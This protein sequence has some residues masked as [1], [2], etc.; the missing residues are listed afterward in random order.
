M[1]NAALKKTINR[2]FAALLMLTL[3]LPSLCLPSLALDDPTTPYTE[4]AIVYNVDF[5][6]VMYEENA[7]APVYPAGTVKIMTALLAFER[8]SDLSEQ[9]TVTEEMIKGITGNTAGFK[10]G[11]E[12]AVRDLLAALIVSNSNDAACIL[13]FAVAGDILSFVDLMN[14]RAAELGMENTVYTNPTGIHHDQMKT[15]ARDVMKV[16]AAALKYQFYGEF[17]ASATYTVPATNLAESRLLRNRNYFVSTFYNL[18]YYRESIGG[19]SCSYTGQAGTCLALV[20]ANSEGHRFITVIMGAE[21]PEEPEDG[22]I[23]ACEEALTLMS[24]AYKAYAHFTVISTGDMI[25]EIPVSLSSRVDHVIALPAE[26]I[27]AFLPVDTDLQTELRTEYTLNSDSLTAPV[28]KGQ[29]IGSL[30]AYVGSDKIG[31]VDL[32]AKNNVDRSM[33]LSMRAKISAFFKHPLV[34]A[35]IVLA[36]VLIVLYVIL[37]AMRISRRNNKVR[38]KNNRRR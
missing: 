7:D 24:W 9:I 14:S 11:E 17:A 3:C 8:F 12:V 33:W 6:T 1:Q 19:I 10:A 4:N 35:V 27:T 21:E 37:T 31:T 36:A 25:C 13:A 22:V 16:T 28:S 29:V 38:Y 26:K 32:I 34:I 2:L 18:N 30:T 23:Y 15:T 5:A 20:G